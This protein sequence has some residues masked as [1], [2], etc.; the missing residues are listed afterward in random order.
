VGGKSGEVRVERSLKEGSL[1]RVGAKFDK[2]SSKLSSRKAKVK[3]VVALVSSDKKSIV[4]VVCAAVV[5]IPAAVAT[6]GAVSSSL[7]FVSL[8]IQMVF[9]LLMP[10]TMMV[11]AGLAVFQPVIVTSAS[12]AFTVLAALSGLIV[13]Y[14]PR[15]RNIKG[16]VMAT[17][18]PLSSLWAAT[19]P[20]ASTSMEIYQGLKFVDPMKP[21]LMNPEYMQLFPDLFFSGFMDLVPKAYLVRGPVEVLTE[22]MGPMPLFPLKVTISAAALAVAMYAWYSERHNL[23]SRMQGKLVR[24]G[25]SESVLSQ[26]TYGGASELPLSE[27]DVPK[28]DFA[29]ESRKLQLK[30]WEERFKLRPASDA[31]PAKWSVDDL[32]VELRRAG[33]EDCSDS[34]RDARIDGRVAMTLTSADE[35]DVR[36]ELGVTSLGERRRLLLFCADLRER[37]RL[38]EQTPGAKPE[39]PDVVPGADA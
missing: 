10:V 8:F 15:T 24:G 34:L 31:N 6:V 36:D 29:E 13:G 7:I 18:L 21:M 39:P 37:Q 5:I 33:L 12:M 1:R 3:A 14:F 23:R 2:I 11:G 19:L 9:I 28:I 35:R 22:S 26:G 30:E 32:F 16:L 25:G 27:A 20:V 38:A 17:I 4:L